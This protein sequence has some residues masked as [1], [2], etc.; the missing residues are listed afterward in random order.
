MKSTDIIAAGFIGFA[1]YWMFRE[2]EQTLKESPVTQKSS[3]AVKGA[4]TAPPSAP[5]AQN[6]LQSNEIDPETAQITQFQSNSAEPAFWH[7]SK[8]SQDALLRNLSRDYSSPRMIDDDSQYEICVKASNAT[9]T[10]CAWTQY[11]SSICG[12]SSFERMCYLSDQMLSIFD[13]NISQGISIADSRESAIMHA[14][15]LG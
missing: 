10:P 6:P 4:V 11:V 8:T 7:I 3:E 1:V 2:N 15:S 5:T 12:K 14:I 9:G 13:S